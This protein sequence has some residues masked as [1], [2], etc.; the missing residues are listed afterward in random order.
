[1]I[2][3]EQGEIGNKELLGPSGSTPGRVHG[4]TS[5]VGQRRPQPHVQRCENPRVQ[6]DPSA[7]K[8]PTF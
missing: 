2:T 8:L 1:M 6:Y 4:G 5:F 7:A 3:G